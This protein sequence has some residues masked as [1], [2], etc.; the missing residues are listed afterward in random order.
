MLDSGEFVDFQSDDNARLIEII[1][2]HAAHRAQ[3]AAPTS[4]LAQWFVAYGQPRVAIARLKELRIVGDAPQVEIYCPMERVDVRSGRGSKRRMRDL[5]LF[6][7][8]MFARFDLT[9]ST[10]AT[11]SDAGLRLAAVKAIDGVSGFL[12]KTA[13]GWPRAMPDTRFFQQLLATPIIVRETASLK[14]NDVVRVLRGPLAG[15]DGI[16]Q[17]CLGRLDTK[18]RVVILL[19]M[20]GAPVPVE[21][22]TGDVEINVRV[23]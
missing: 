6:G 23:G 15:H 17:R 1:N 18:Q 14:A 3:R 4:N 10:Q 20:L 11:E 9:R 5:P 8:Y 2:D 7:A 12:G 21:L 16:V 22:S 19:S 13:D